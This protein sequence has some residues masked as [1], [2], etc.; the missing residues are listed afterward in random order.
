MDPS[1]PGGQIDELNFNFCLTE[2]KSKLTHNNHTPW[3]PTFNNTYVTYKIIP[4]DKSRSSPLVCCEGRGYVGATEKW[5]Y[6][7]CGHQTWT[8]KIS[9]GNNAAKPAI[10]CKGI[11]TG[12]MV[13]WAFGTEN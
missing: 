12:T 2:Y 3:E 4:E 6:L 7:G 9:W 5:Q 13:E 1:F 8:G 10:R 11:A